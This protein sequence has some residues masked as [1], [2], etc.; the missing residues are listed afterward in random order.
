MQSAENLMPVYSPPRQSRS[1]QGYAAGS[2]PVSTV[3]FQNVNAGPDDLAVV[4]AVR[5]C[6]A[7]VDLE[8]VTKKQGLFVLPLR[9]G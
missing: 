7:E 3:D 1:P 8:R 9:Y 5:A 2:R 4:E 6:L